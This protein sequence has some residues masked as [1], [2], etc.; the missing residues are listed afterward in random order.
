MI[1]RKLNR[2][3]SLFFYKNLISK[4]DLCFDVGA[5]IGKKSELF[6]SLKAKVIAFEPQT[7]CF[8]FLDKINNSNFTYYPFGVGSKNE[9]KLLHLANHLEVATFS[10]KMIDFYTTE[11]LKWKNGEK[12]IVKK[13]DTLIDEFGLPNFCKID[14]EGF[15]LEILSNLSHKIP[16]IEFEFNEAFID[17]TLLTLDSIDKL[18]N[19]KFN[20]ILNETPKFIN[21]NWSSIS[22]IKEQIINLK[23]E[24]LHGNLFAKLNL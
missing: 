13:L 10:H 4:N 22:E 1:F 20:F 24:K 8:P 9:N 18:G 12:V 2:Y 15:E 6:L 19:Y 17:E 3:K 23:K 14:T 5:N 11:N 16:K 7:K 21:K